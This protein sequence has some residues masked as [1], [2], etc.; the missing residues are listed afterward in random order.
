MNRNSP[1]EEQL[2]NWILDNITT[3]AL[4]AY[5]KKEK[6]ENIEDISRAHKAIFMGLKNE[7][8]KNRISDFHHTYLQENSRNEH[9]NSTIKISGRIW[10]MQIAALFLLALGIYYA[11][12]NLFVSSDQLT[13]DLFTEYYLVNERSENTPLAN[14]MMGSFITKDYK[15]VLVAY[16]TIEKASN[17]EKF[18]AGYAS[19]MLHDYNKA[20]S[21]FQDVIEQNKKSGIDLYQDEAEYFLTLSYIQTNKYD[22]AYQLVQII[23]KNSNHTYHS[24]IT[25]INKLR[26]WIKTL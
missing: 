11:Q 23:Q 12:A 16:T 3:E 10:I 21:L 17:R 2:D 15:A 14:T 20:V 1:L 13:E 7:Q 19:F 22:E 25:S 4:T 6:I 5:A 8:L 26:L 18:L 24:K 9:K